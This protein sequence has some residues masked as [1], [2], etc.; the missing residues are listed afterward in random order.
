MPCWFYESR[1]DDV[2]R[3]S[4]WAMNIIDPKNTSRTNYEALENSMLCIAIRSRLKN[5]TKQ[6]YMPPNP[7]ISSLKEKHDLNDA[8]LLFCCIR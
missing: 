8:V 5:K 4:G 1:N 7:T 3:D 2:L 6:K